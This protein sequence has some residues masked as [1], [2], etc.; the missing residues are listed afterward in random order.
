MVGA[1]VAL[2]FYLLQKSLG[3]LPFL[4]GGLD[5]QQNILYCFCL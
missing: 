5:R 1:K 4:G 3:D 2:L